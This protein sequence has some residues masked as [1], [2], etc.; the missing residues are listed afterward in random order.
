MTYALSSFADFGSLGSLL[1]GL[2]MKTLVTDTLAPPVAK[3]TI[4]P[5]QA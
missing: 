1:G 4:P 5:V 2:G 3:S